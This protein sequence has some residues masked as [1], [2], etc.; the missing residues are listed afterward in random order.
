MRPCA[1]SRFLMRSS[2]FFFCP[3]TKPADYQPAV[4]YGHYIRRI[5]KHMSTSGRQTRPALRR[6][7]AVHPTSSRWLSLLVLC[8][9]FLMIILDSTI[10]NVALPSI[11]R[12]LGF[13]QSSLAW[14]VNAY[15]IAFGGLLLLAGRLGDLIGRKRMFVGGLALFTAASMLAGAATSQALLITARFVQGVGG[16][17]VSAVSLGMLIALFPEPRERGK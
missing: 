14:V 16:A 7:G 17:M 12:D 1:I 6:T 10:V 15:L 4:K 5:A 13:S 2:A 9:G 11:Q 3:D 8:A